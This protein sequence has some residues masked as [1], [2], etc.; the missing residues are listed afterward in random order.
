MVGLEVE[1]QIVFSRMATTNKSKANA[2][3]LFKLYMLC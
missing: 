2:L 1:F 3:K